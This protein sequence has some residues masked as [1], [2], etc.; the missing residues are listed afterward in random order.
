[1]RTCDAHIRGAAELKRATPIVIVVRSL[2]SRRGGRP[3]A[4]EG[5]IR[6]PHEVVRPPN[7]TSRCGHPD[8]EETAHAATAEARN[9]DPIAE[10]WRGFCTV[11]RPTRA[12]A[13]SFAVPESLFQEASSPM[14]DHNA[15]MGLRVSLPS[16][17][18]DRLAARHAA[19]IRG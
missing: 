16:C 4:H 5:S 18:C 17:G 14:G 3:G 9:S 6:C 2:Y 13:L 1:M 11:S 7:S 8:A 19:V 15:E 10:C 12:E